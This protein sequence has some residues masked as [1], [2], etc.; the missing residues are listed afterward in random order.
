[1]GQTV[2]SLHNHESVL[3]A[4]RASNALPS[5]VASGSVVGSQES[6]SKLSKKKNV[7]KQIVT[8]TVGC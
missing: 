2:D 6:L 4:G 1:M 3:H 8:V 7:P 5:S